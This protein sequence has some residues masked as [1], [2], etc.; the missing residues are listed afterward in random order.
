M[1]DKSP[2]LDHKTTAPSLAYSCGTYLHSSGHYLTPHFASCLSPPP[3]KWQE[4]RDCVW[5]S[6]QSSSYDR[7]EHQ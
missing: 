1:P 6:V 4:G 2:S 5:F 7:A 3:Y